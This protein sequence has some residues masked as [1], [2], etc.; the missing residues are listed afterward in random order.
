MSAQVSAAPFAAALL[1]LAPLGAQASSPLALGEERF[2]V[3]LG[4][5][6]T[7][8]NTGMTI[9]ID[10][11]DGH[12]EIDVEDDLGMDSSRTAFRLDGYWRMAPR[13]RLFFGY[14]ALNR[15]S[16]KTLET[17]IEW[18]DSI[19]P[20]GT[21]VKSNFDWSVIPVSYAYSFYQTP[22]IEAAAS[23]GIHW[24]SLKSDISANVETQSRIIGDSKEISNTEGPLPVLGLRLD[25]QPAPRWI[26]GGSVQF[27]SLSTGKYDGQLVDFGLT[28]EYLLNE[29]WGLGVGYNYFEVDLD[30]D[31]DHWDGNLNYSYS[32]IQAFVSARF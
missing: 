8:F 23:V 2:E 1:C 29:T 3:N 13:H 21:K 19:Y 4:A 17:E 18:E 6:F 11:N 26:L 24:I 10:S 5:F 7:D 12:R 15:S 30:I 27:F 31:E 16:S 28:A 9:G 22:K 32:G 25:Y 14:Y 20:I